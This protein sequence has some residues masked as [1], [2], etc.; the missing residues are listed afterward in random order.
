M[1]RPRILSPLSTRRCSNSSLI[2]QQLLADY[3]WISPNQYNDMH[4]ALT[5]G[6]KGLTGDAANIKQGDDFLSQIVPAIMASHA[7]KNHGVIILW[8]DESE[9]DGVAG[10]NPDDLNHTVG[11]IVISD[12]AHANVNGLPYASPVAFTHS[13]DVRTMQNIFRTAGLISPTRSTP[14]TSPTFSSPAQSRRSPEKFF[15]LTPITISNSPAQGSPISAPLP[16]PRP[17]KI[18]SGHLHVAKPNL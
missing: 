13:S 3:N 17:H 15:A 12:R 10:D 4:T 11:E 7:Y 14:T 6:Y 1:Q 18:S 2:S 16:S 9:R 8:W 5:G